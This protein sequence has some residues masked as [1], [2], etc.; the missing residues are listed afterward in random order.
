ML[1][2]RL[3]SLEVNAA[4]VVIKHCVGLNR[5]PS[6]WA[7]LLAACDS[8]CSPCVLPHR[9]SHHDSIHNVVLV[10]FQ[11]TDGLG[12]RHVGLSHHQ[13]DVPLLQTSVVHLVEKKTGRGRTLVSVS[14]KWLRKHSMVAQVSEGTSSSSSS[15][16]SLM[17]RLGGMGG[18]SGEE[19]IGTLNFSAAAL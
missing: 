6:A 19:V 2:L 13:L 10:V 18:A 16:S 7:P 12:P 11:C 3:L 15:L 8:C 5:Q 14:C 17:V 1:L 9:R 4:N